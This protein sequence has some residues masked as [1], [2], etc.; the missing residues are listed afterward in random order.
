M[1]EQA[2]RSS[3]WDRMNST[4]AFLTHHFTAN[5]NNGLKQS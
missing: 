3:H 5:T 2:I 4:F 1:E